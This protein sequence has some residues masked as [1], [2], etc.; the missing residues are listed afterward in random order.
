[1]SCLDLFVKADESGWAILDLRPAIRA[2]LAAA[3]AS[4]DG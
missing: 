1:M 4:G 2:I 3:Q